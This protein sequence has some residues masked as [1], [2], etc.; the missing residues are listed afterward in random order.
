MK[1]IVALSPHLEHVDI[2]SGSFGCSIHFSSDYIGEYQRKQLFD[3]EP[4]PNTIKSFKSRGD[5]CWHEARDGIL[6][7]AIDVSKLEC[8]DVD[9]L[10]SGDEEWLRKYETTEP[11]L[12]VSDKMKQLS[13][14]INSND[15]EILHK[16]ED[17]I[18]S[19]YYLEKLELTG[20]VRSIPLSN[21]LMHHG[22][23]L[24]ILAIHEKESP[25]VEDQPGCTVAELDEIRHS[26][27]NLEDITI[28]TGKLSSAE[29]LHDVLSALSRFPKLSVIRLYIPLGIAKT[30]AYTM[31]MFLDEEEQ[32]IEKKQHQDNPYSPLEDPHWLEYFW[33]VLK[34]QKTRYGTP[35]LRELHVKV[36]EWEREISGGGYP[37][38]WILWE[39][40]NRKYF[41]A[42]PVE[43][44]DKPDEIYV[45]ERTS[46][47]LNSK[48][49][50]EK[51]VK[52]PKMVGEHGSNPMSKLKKYARRLEDE[53]F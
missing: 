15:K 26:C 4:S 34:N 38:A 10:Y 6:G 35:Q 40:S 22:E 39:S 52:I 28:D 45:C 7:S 11:R 17:F 32:D 24:K 3:V 49:I 29:S 36:G 48:D 12:V 37:A 53:I 21:V 31:H 25:T 13:L 9:H 1:R 16:I 33:L 44:D 51:T 43:R 50:G 41:I 8:L 46:G 20:N 42:K 47:Q 23:D 5:E 14:E 18:A 19:C 27:P 30:A 2:F